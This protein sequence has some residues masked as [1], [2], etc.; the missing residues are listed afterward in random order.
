MYYVTPRL[1]PIRV[2]GAGR[3]PGGSV[4]WVTGGRGGAGWIAGAGRRGGSRG[5]GVGWVAI[6]FAAICHT[7]ATSACNVAVIYY[8][9]ATGACESIIIAKLHAQVIEV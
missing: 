7:L 8:T 9:C 6:N 4:G 2:R 3:G 1:L 5:C